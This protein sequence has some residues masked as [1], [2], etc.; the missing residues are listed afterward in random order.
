MLP[1]LLTLLACTGEQSSVPTHTPFDPSAPQQA[2][3]FVDM[4]SLK[5][6]FEAYITRQV[7]L[8]D[9]RVVTDIATTPVD[10]MVWR[11]EQVL[12]TDYQE[13]WY[14]VEVTQALWG[15]VPDSALRT[16]ETNLIVKKEGMDDE[17]VRVVAVTVLGDKPLVDSNRKGTGVSIPQ[18]DILFGY[19]NE[20]G[21]L[22][23]EAPSG[24]FGYL[25]L[26]HTSRDPGDVNL[27]I[28]SARART[29]KA[30]GQTTEVYALVDA[31]PTNLH[32]RILYKML[33]GVAGPLEIPP[34]MTPEQA[35]A[36]QFLETPLLRF[37]TGA[38]PA[39][40][41]QHPDIHSSRGMPIEPGMIVATGR[42][43]PFFMLDSESEELVFADTPSGHGWMLS[44]NITELP[45]DDFHG[46]LIDAMGPRLDG[47]AGDVPTLPAG[48]EVLV[49]AYD[50]AMLMVSVPCMPKEPGAPVRMTV[51]AINGVGVRH[52]GIHSP[53]CDGALMDLPEEVQPVLEGHWPSEPF[54]CRSIRVVETQGLFPGD[55][56]TWRVQREPGWPDTERVTG[57]IAE[58]RLVRTPSPERLVPLVSKEDYVLA[59]RE[60]PSPTGGGKLEI[61]RLTIGP[62]SVESVFTREWGGSAS[63]VRWNVDGEGVVTSTDGQTCT[64]DEASKTY[65]CS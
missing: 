9:N 6:P 29:L 23:V 4:A 47:C 19:R 10:R 3:E 30:R 16:Q 63:A 32:R 36:Q 61:V 14:R 56:P 12:V 22:E 7:P 24:Q 65:G 5:M 43:G 1:L 26:L 50:G 53:V 39:T 44:S 60:H 37:V 8:A 34:T 35:L 62:A 52:M 13:G 18:G 54:S 33:K 45:T 17:E 31:T 25:P 41:L 40:F 28:T 38:E 21:Y 46:E 42:R 48:S 2:L 51:G 59:Q 55:T 11:G 57:L 27:A 58:G 64:Y 49:K 20:G 15:W